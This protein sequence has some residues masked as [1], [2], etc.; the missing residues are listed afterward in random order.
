MALRGDGVAG[1]G[2]MENG[3]TVDERSSGSEE[4]DEGGS[5]KVLQESPPS[6]EDVWLGNVSAGNAEGASYVDLPWG[7]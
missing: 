3:L 1:E 4:D 7:Q 5:A 6:R 2:R